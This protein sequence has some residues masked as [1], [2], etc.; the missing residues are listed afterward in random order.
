VFEK[1]PETLVRVIQV[2]ICLNSPMAVCINVT[3]VLLNICFNHTI[4]TGHF[5]H[6]FC[7]TYHVF[8]FVLFFSK[9]PIYS[10]QGSVSSFAYWLKINLKGLSNNMLCTYLSITVMLKKHMIIVMCIYLP[11]LWNSECHI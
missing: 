11:K 7:I 2:Q 9:A 1:Y 4:I 8:C 10:R 3:S 5:L 6:L